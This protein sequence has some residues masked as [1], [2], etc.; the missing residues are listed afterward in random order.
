MFGQREWRYLERGVGNGAGAADVVES[1]AVGEVPPLGALLQS[2]H[3]PRYP[4]PVVDTE[5][6][7]TEPWIKR[8]HRFNPVWLW[9]V[10][11]QLG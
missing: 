7:R 5:K 8:M 6:N 10:L 11:C 2:T 4:S 1:R 9:S 3:R